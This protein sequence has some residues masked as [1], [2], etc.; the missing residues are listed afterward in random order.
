[1]LYKA[2]FEYIRCETTLSAHTVLAYRRDLQALQKF[3]E[4]MG[5]DA[6]DPRNLTNRDIRL[7]IASMAERKLTNA[8]IAR[9]LQAVRSL[10]RYLLRYRGVSVDPTQ[11]LRSPKRAKNLPVFITPGES[12]QTIACAPQGDEFTGTRDALIIELLYTTGMRS[13]ELLALH[14]CDIDL[15]RCELKAHGKRNKDRLIP[16]GSTLKASIEHYMQ[17][18]NRQCQGAE[19][20]L[21]CPDGRALNYAAVYRIVRRAMTEAGVKS[22]RRSPHVL[23]HSFATDL[24]NNGADLR[25][26]QQLLGHQSLATTQHYTHISYRELQQNY[27]SAHPRALKNKN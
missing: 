6:S 1:M 26:V 19:A 22:K 10:F 23:R 7:W 4:S 3:V 17:V 11:G 20:F 13:A 21:T 12:E 8:T 15:D 14:D 9:R 5:L 16:F 18:R 27:Q 24:L 25:S 2:F